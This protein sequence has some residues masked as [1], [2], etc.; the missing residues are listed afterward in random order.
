MLAYGLYHGQTAPTHLSFNHLPQD[1][2][3]LY[4]QQERLGW[5][6]LY[7]GCLTPLWLMLLQQ[8]HP[9]T[10]STHYFAKVTT[11]I[12]Q[13]VLKVWKMHNDHL[14]PSNQ[15][16]EDCSQLQAAVHQIF[17]V[18]QQDPQLQAMVENLNLDQIMEWSTRQICQW[19]LHSNTHM[20][21]H[22]KVAK[23]QAHLHTHHI[24][25]YFPQ[26]TPKLSRT[27]VD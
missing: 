16:H 23:L 8:Y 3:A 10:N 6:Q 26:H 24:C 27:S 12:W 2:H 13:A 14:H 1:L 25:Q 9:Q 19:V 18:A 17:F 4:L 7:Y 21:A 11:L 20:R 15:E 5:K 22:W